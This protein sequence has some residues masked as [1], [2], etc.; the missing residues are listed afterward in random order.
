M[1]SVLYIIGFDA[2]TPAVDKIQKYLALSVAAVVS[3]RLY[4]QLKTRLPQKQ[5]PS[6]IPIVPLPQ[7][8]DS[9]KQ[10]LHEG[11]VTVLTSGDP[12][13]FGIGRKLIESF[14]DTDIRIHPAL[15]SMQMAFSRFCLPWED[16]Q[17]ISLHGRSSERLAARLL[18]HPKVFLFTDPKN[19]PDTIALQLLE[20]C[21]KEAVSCIIMYVGEHLGSSS[22]RLVKGNI[23]EIAKGK[24]A[25]PNVVILLNP[26]AGHTSNKPEFGL[27]ENEIVHSRGLLTKNEVRAAAVHALRLQRGSVFWDVGAGSGSVG[28]EVARLFPDVSVFAIEKKREQWQNILA[29]R[30][31][32]SAWNM[33]LIK[34]EAPDVLEDLPKPDRIFVGGSGGNLSQI[35]ERC[36]NELQDGGIIV[37]NAVIAK[38]ANIAPGVLYNLGLTVEISK[39]AVERFAYPEEE[40]VTFNPITMITGKKFQE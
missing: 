38:T 37:V 9:I 25:N 33:K 18:R 10:S 29:N 26:R 34:G 20:E 27:H 32:F 11:S 17:F 1:K 31:R 22:E 40:R 15:S 30:D 8:I 2:S 5:L 4:E 19:S 14:P 35:L 12:L 36:V 13:F 16:A 28:L 23:Q 21:G 24:F 39:I 7:C 3:K 6:V